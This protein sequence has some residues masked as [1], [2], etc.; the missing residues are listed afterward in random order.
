[1]NSAPMENQNNQEL[2]DKLDRLS[3]HLGQDRVEREQ[4][5]K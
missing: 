1:V 4:R 3:N 2:L 5:R